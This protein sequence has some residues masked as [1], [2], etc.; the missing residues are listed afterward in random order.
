[1]SSPVLFKT[2]ILNGTNNTIYQNICATV[3]LGKQENKHIQQLEENTKILGKQ[4]NIILCRKIFC[5]TYSV[6]QV[7]F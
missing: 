6:R 4:I 2:D 5:G 3:L 7:Q 1:M